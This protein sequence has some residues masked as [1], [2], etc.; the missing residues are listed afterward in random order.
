MRSGV[1]AQAHSVEW[2]QRGRRAAETA[3][4]CE[5]WQLAIL[6]PTLWRTGSQC[7]SDK[8][9]VIWSKRDFCAT[10]RAM[11]F[12]TSCRRDRFETDVPARRVIAVIKL[13]SHYSRHHCL[14][15]LSGE[16][17]SN[18]AQ[19]TDVEIWRFAC[20]RIPVYRKIVWSQDRH[21][22]SWLMSEVW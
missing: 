20:F 3:G 16:R 18:V 12:W 11:V 13:W 14:S 19:G 2:V 21:P 4:P 5:W 6:K 10:T 9:G 22:D 1:I 15:C 17:G 8:T 7:N